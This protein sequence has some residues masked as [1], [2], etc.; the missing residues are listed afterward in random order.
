[1]TK[2]ALR[3]RWRDPAFLAKLP[4]PLDREPS[5]NQLRSLDLRGV[6]KLA[7]GDPLW[8]F[9]I[10]K[11]KVEDIDVSFGDGV[12]RVYDSEISRL[13]ARQFKFD[14]ASTFMKSM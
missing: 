1:M 6:P 11:A 12:L 7:N 13:T 4:I 3:K 14:Q 5:A 2:S 9:V 8:H 10:R